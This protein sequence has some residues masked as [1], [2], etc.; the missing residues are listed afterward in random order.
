GRA[1]TLLKKAFETQEAKRGFS[2]VEILSNCPVGWGM[3][4]P[5]SMEHVEKDVIETYPLGVLVDRSLAAAE[6]H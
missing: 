1:K 2:I 3:T 6:A 4:A 5:T